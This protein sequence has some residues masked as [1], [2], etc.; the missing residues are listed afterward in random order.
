MIEKHRIDREK[1]EEKAQS[2]ILTKFYGSSGK[3]RNIMD[4]IHSQQ[5]E[6]T[7]RRAEKRI[8]DAIKRERILIERSNKKDE[9]EKQLKLDMARRMNLKPGSIIPRY[10]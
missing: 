7:K 9:R 1:Q 10:I 6:A 4:K 2:L 5:E 3:E 8:S